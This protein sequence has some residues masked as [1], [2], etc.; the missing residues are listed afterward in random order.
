MLIANLSLNQTLLTFLVLCETNLD[1]STDSCN[2][3]VRGYLPLIGKNF[4]T[5]ICC[6]AVYVKEGLPFK[7]ELSLKN[8]ADSYLCFWLALLHSVSFFFLYRSPS[9]SLCMV[10]Y[11][12]S[13]DIDEVLSINPSAN[14]F[15]FVFTNDLTQMVNFPT[16]IPNCD[17]LSSALLDLFLSSDASIFSTMAFPPLGNSDHVVVSVSIDFPSNSQCNA[18]FQRIAYDYSCADLDGLYDHLKDLPWEYIFKLGASAAA[19]EFCG[20]GFRLELMYMSLIEN[21]RPSLI[22]LHGFQL[23]VLLP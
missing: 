16:W 15:A 2:F 8:S 10:F 1:E 17:S 4:S 18:P 7:W 3:S 14:A 9:S 22:H 23:L 13:S 12:I 19:S 20:C 11:S 5:H 21:I 6:L